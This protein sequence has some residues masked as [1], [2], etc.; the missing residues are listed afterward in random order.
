MAKKASSQFYLDH[1][2]ILT[3]QLTKSWD[4]IA[5]VLAGRVKMLNLTVQDGDFIIISDASIEVGDDR[6]TAI[7]AAG[8]RLSKMLQAQGKRCIVLTAPATME[9]QALDPEVLADH[10]WYRKEPD[11]HG[12][13]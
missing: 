11:T 7:A 10:G 4:T 8:Q 2:T 13:S 5:A 6:P 12:A 1:I 9:I 3:D